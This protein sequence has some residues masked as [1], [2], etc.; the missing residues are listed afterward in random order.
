MHNFVHQHLRFPDNKNLVFNL[1]IK[2]NLL[3]KNKTQQLQYRIQVNVWE[4]V[5]L[6]RI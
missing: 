5:E 6:M 3:K 1:L 4:E 2:L